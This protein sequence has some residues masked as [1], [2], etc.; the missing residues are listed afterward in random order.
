[1]SAY[2]APQPDDV[3][4]PWWEAT[5]EH[6]LLLQRC[7]ACGSHQHPPRALCTECGR[8]DRL[9]FAETSG[10]AVVDS[11]TAVHR[12]PDPKAE[13]P[14]VIARVE[15]AEGPIL[16]TRLLGDPSGP[17]WQIGDAVAL[18]WADLNDGRALPMFRAAH[19]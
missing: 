9:D 19:S 7:D 5:R 6:R 4:T 14:Y 8:M 2:S 10:S 11:W 13:L 3:T 18:D 1:M 16:L 12:A 17:Q 15:L